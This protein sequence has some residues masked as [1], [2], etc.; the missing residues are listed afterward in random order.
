MNQIEKIAVI[1][2]Q[3]ENIARAYTNVDK[4]I[5]KFQKARITEDIYSQTMGGQ[6][7]GFTERIEYLFNSICTDQYDLIR[8]REYEAGYNK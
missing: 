1:S 7:G 2:E 5:A 4:A 3:K 6:I 8:L